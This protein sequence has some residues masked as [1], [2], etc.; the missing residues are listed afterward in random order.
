MQPYIDYAITICRNSS[1][2]NINKV[3]KL[4]NRIAHI[5]GDPSQPVVYTVF[6]FKMA[7]IMV[8]DMMEVI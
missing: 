7:S 8:A 6:G 4:Q 3:Q 2:R 1:I 5:I